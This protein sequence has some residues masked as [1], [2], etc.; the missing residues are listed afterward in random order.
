MQ[1]EDGLSGT[2][3]DVEDGAIS[4]LDVALAGDLGGG[5]MAAANDFGV[6]R[7]QLLSAPRNVSWE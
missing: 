4:V 1:V 2:G 5:E 7:T 6:S 3:A